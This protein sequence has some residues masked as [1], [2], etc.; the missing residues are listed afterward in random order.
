MGTIHQAQ[1][2]LDV[3]ACTKKLQTGKYLAYIEHRTGGA[4]AKGTESFIAGV[5][6]DNAAA[7]A[8]AL[9]LLQA[10]RSNVIPHCSGKDIC[11]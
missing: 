9:R 2:A 5:F 10:F 4:A 1:V 11:S 6:D 8:A 7:Q 3:A